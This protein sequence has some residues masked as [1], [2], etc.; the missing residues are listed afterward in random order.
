MKSASE[1]DAFLTDR[2]KTAYESAVEEGIDPRC[3]PIHL[4]GPVPVGDEI[5]TPDYSEE[6]QNNWKFLFNR[7]MDLL[8]GRAGDA[9]MNGVEELGITSEGIPSLA[10]MS[11]RME[12]VT[13][14]RIARIPGLLH[15]KDFFNLISN[16]VFPSTDYLRGADELDYTPAPDCFH[17]MFGHMPMLSEPA[18]ADYYQ[19]FGQAAMNA[20]GHQRVQLERLHWFTVEFGLVRQENGLRIF[21]AGILSSKGEVTHAVNGEAKVIPFSADRVVE[22]EYEVWNLQPRLFALESFDQL[23][24]EFRN[25]TTNQGLL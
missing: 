25:W 17:D 5:V 24:S 4:N 13:N 6:D 20:E 7:Q 21:G 12:A 18:F 2:G 8:P 9:F 16:R 23:V 14:W 19:L 11:E 22:Q 3:V 1:S 15:E 10:K